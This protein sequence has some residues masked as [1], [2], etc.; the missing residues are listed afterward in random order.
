MK[1]IALVLQA[2]VTFARQAEF[3]RRYCG[4]SL[5]GA[6][7]KMGGFY[8]RRSL[9]TLLRNEFKKSSSIL[10]DLESEF[11]CVLSEQLDLLVAVSLS[12]LLGKPK[13]GE[14]MVT[15]CGAAA[16]NAPLGERQRA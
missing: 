5:R 3:R 2:A 12:V 14:A 10:R 13:P 7:S 1:S 15:F 16:N 4:A 8:F 6:P 11:N 9:E